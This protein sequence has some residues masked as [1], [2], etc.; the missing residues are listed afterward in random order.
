M[1]K[2]DLVQRKFERSSIS[3]LLLCAAPLLL[4]GCSAT[5]IYGVS[6]PTGYAN[7]SKGSFVHDDSGPE[8]IEM[9]VSEDLFSEPNPVEQLVTPVDVSESVVSHEE[10][11]A[12][13]AA[14]DTSG[15]PVGSVEMHDMTPKPVMAQNQGG[16][17]PLTKAQSMPHHT[18][19]PTPAPV[20]H[21]TAITPSPMEVAAADHMSAPAAHNQW[22]EVSQ[23]LIATLFKQTGTPLKP[24]Y[25]TT[26]A[27]APSTYPELEHSIRN[28]LAGYGVSVLSEPTARPVVLEYDVVRLGSGKS[29]QALITFILYKTDGTVLEANRMFSIR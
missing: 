27:G 3:K 25:I 2:S 20:M 21:D 15:Q 10:M 17:I 7:T 1:S 14:L 23:T 29:D 8:P 28:T 22:S 18:A 11:A 13:Q 26:V 16:P 19:T 24:V 4:A 12:A 6:I 5:N 9:K